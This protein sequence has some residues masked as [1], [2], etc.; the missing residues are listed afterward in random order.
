MVGGGP[1]GLFSAVYAARRGLQSTVIE[2]RNDDGDKACGE[3]LMPDA[4]RLLRSVDVHPEG[5]PF[6]G[7]R[8]LDGNGR[9]Q[10][11]ADL[12]REPGLGVR[13]TELMRA[14]RTAAVREGVA[15]TA[16]K[17]VDVDAARSHPS[18]TT[19][20]GE[21][22]TA[23]VVL[24]CDGLGSHVRKRLGLDA[25]PSSGISGHGPLARYG[26][27][28]H[29]RTRPWSADVEVY[30]GSDG[31]AYVTPVA[32]D[33]VGVAMLGTRGASFDE[34]LSRFTAL[35]R[36]LGE[37]DRVGR[38]T[39]AGPLRRRSVSAGLGTVMLVGDAAGYVDALTGEGLSVGF[40]SAKAAVDAATSGG[41]SRYPTEWRK[42]TRRSRLSTE[43]L[44]RGTRV[45]LL[46]KSL[47]PVSSSAPHTFG[48]VVRWVA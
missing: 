29:Y 41:V 11:R 7:I 48:T 26:L 43:L 37:A 1:V 18:V 21:V 4:V 17:A 46:R 20:D 44:L 47:L 39:G 5:M 6:R 35:R 42:V 28:G 23:D 38:V 33:L 40:R 36:R 14:L 22:I 16:A 27:V 9:R 25:S 15:V 2:S 12:G 31:E 32:G 3:G 10:V 45:A 30:W 13:R 34:R 19:D 24:A 8:Y